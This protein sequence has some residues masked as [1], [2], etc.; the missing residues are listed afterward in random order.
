MAYYRRCPCC[1]AN[2]DP[3]EICDCQDD[4]KKGGHPRRTGNDL[5]LY[6][7]SI[8]PRGKSKVNL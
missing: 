5:R 4:E 2:N 1:G 3:G 7:H 6:T 8:L